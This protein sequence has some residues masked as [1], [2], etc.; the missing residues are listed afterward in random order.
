MD[1]MGLY[2][3]IAMN[4]IALGL[5]GLDKHRARTHG[6]RVPEKTLFAAALLGGGWGAWCGI[7]L[8]RHKTR[9]WYFVVLIPLIA[10]AEYGLL[11][12]L[13]TNGM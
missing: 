6:W 12:W 2:A 13:L 8:F 9:H 4:V 7:Y 5:F 1:K 3:L 10:V 11:A